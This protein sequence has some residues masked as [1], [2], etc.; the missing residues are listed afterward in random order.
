MEHLLS[1]RGL[2]AEI[3]AGRGAVSVAERKSTVA[4]T[5][6]PAESTGAG[7]TGAGVALET[8]SAGKMGIH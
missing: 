1:A 7:G 4:G 5:G 3:A 6:T 8:G 2:S